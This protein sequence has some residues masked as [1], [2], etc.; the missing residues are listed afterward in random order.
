MTQDELE[1][2]Q[3]IKRAKDAQEVVRKFDRIALAFMVIFV[4]A[5]LT[6]IA[7]SAR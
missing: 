3:E 5:I 6:V 2:E 7:A 4:I 1:R